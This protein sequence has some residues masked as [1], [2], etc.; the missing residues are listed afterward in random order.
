MLD[1]TKYTSECTHGFTCRNCAGGDRGRRHL[2]SLR[3][4]LSELLK[5][6]CHLYGAQGQR[7]AY[8]A[9]ATMNFV[10]SCSDYVRQVALATT[11]TVNHRG[12]PVF[13][14]T[15]SMKY[16]D[17]VLI[18]GPDLKNNVP[19]DYGREKSLGFRVLEQDRL[20]S[21]Q[22]FNL[23]KKQEDISYPTIIH[24]A[25]RPVPHGPDLPILSP[26]NTLDN[27]SNDLVVV[28]F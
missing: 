10:R 8:L 28:V 27:I 16:N 26:P 22:G 24:S 6:H 4:S 17:M 23:K 18:R 3:G 25:I 20:V 12:K 2:S 14:E 9:H 19:K 5:S 1:V 21:M 11:T 7:Q 13:I 15:E